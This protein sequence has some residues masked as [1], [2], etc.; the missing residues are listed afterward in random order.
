MTPPTGLANGQ[1][2][3]VTASGFPKNDSLIVVECLAIATGPSS[4]NLLLARYVHSDDSGRVSA[5][6]Q[7][8]KIVSGKTCNSSN[9]CVVSVSELKNPPP[10]EVDQR[11]SFV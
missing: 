10:Y 3:Q 5:T 1:K 7:V 8:T 11:I 6:L 9:P 4:C 2:V